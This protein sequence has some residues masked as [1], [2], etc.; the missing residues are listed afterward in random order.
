MHRLQHRTYLQQPL[1]VALH[2][3]KLVARLD[4]LHVGYSKEQIDEEHFV[5][6]ALYRIDIDTQFIERQVHI[7]DRS[8]T[9]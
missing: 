5:N 1:F 4:A 9:F 7:V 2:D 6:S 3:V 8:K